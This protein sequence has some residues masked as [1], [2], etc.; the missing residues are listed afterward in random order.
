MDARAMKECS[1]FPKAPAL[2]EPHHQTVFCHIQD[3]HWG[4]GYT[5]ERVCERERERERER[6][7]H[8]HTRIYVYIYIYRERE[9]ETDRQTEKHTYI[10]TYVHSHRADTFIITN[11][12]YAYE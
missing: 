8:T 2:L 5:S 11:I 6:D 1:A 7:T 9:R 3:S 12:N 4:L 10:Y